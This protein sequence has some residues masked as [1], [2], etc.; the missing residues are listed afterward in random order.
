VNVLVF[1][2]NKLGDNVVF[3]PVIQ[4]I[5]RYRP[6]WRLLLFTNSLALP[7]YGEARQNEK[8]VV[9]DRVPFLSAW[10]N[11]NELQ[12]LVRTV[13]EFKPDRCLFASDQGNVAY[14]LGLASGARV[15]IGRKRAFHRVPGAINRPEPFDPSGPAAL[16][17]WKLLLRLV[18]DTE[19]PNLPELPPWPDLDHLLERRERA[20]APGARGNG[21]RG[22]VIH[23]GAS[24]DFQ[25]WPLENFVSLA[26]RLC[27]DHRVSWIREQSKN[28]SD[29]DSAV[30]IVDTPS[31]ADLVAVLARTLLFIGNNSGPFQIASALGRPSVIVNGPSGRCW[32][33]FWFPDR[34]RMLRDESVPCVPCEAYYA[35]CRNPR[36]MQC[37]GK[38]TVDMVETEA[39][40]WLE[41][42]R[43]AGTAPS[44]GVG[45]NTERRTLDAE[46]QTERCAY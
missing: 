41:R 38:W 34:M 30:E 12:S 40:R 26:N 37:M 4:G 36:R 13:R 27:N 17:G 35:E 19:G 44:G 20:G 3:L 23:A 21:E 28:A 15:R 29:L 32:D 43:V 31:V 25:R 24:K 7:L 45:S 11:P 8:Y 46:R 6:D 10:R 2:I 39:R 33:P 42:C 9:R 16:D 22:I 5:R 18:E 1:K 14:L